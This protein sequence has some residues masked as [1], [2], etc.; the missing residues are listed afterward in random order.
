M[1]WLGKWSRRL[2]FFAIVVY[3]GA[4]IYAGFVGTANPNAVAAT[5]ALC[6][7]TLLVLGRNFQWRRDIRSFGEASGVILAIPAA[8][9]WLVS[10]HDPNTSQLAIAV[11]VAATLALSATLVILVAGY[12][13]L[14]R[15]LA[16]L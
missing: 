14:F 16:S 1:G 13:W 3:A 10:A 15:W 12:A 9:F 5:L 4:A 8:W 7:A 6:A 11:G 2:V